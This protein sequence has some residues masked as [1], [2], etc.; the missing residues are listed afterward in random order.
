MGFA[1][2]A[3]EQAPEYLDARDVAAVLGV[4]VPDLRELAARGQFAPLVVLS[5]ERARVHVADLD[6]WERRNTVGASQAFS[7]RLSSAARRRWMDRHAPASSSGPEREEGEDAS[8]DV[9]SLR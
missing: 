5:R 8:Q 1:Q 2:H 4:S 6:A 9:A 7:P 3:P